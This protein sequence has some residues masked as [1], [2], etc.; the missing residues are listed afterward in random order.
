M[1]V[2]AAFYFHD[3]FET[4]LLKR[5]LR[6]RSQV[7]DPMLDDRAY[8]VLIPRK[9]IFVLLS[10]TMAEPRKNEAMTTLTMLAGR[11]Y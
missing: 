6:V 4:R 11:E 5:S 1:M 2:I 8:A 3:I 9:D 7:R 10:T